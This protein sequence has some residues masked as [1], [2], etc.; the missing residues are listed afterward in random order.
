MAKKYIELA[1]KLNALASG[2]VAGEK[3]NAQKALENLMEKYGISMAELEENTQQ[4]VRF[5][6]T[7]STRQ[8]FFQVAMSV[9]GNRGATYRQHAKIQNILFLEA[10]VAEHIEIQAKYDFYK[11]ALL[12]EQKT[13]FRAFVMKHNLYNIDAEGKTMDEL[14]TEELEAIAKAANLARGMEHHAYHKALTAPEN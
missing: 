4:W 8:L 3:Q 10:T 13:L 5:I 12:Q 9:I 2:G 1:K 7:R 6:V 14:T 11:S